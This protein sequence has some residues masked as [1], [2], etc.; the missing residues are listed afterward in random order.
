MVGKFGPIRGT[1]Q[2]MLVAPIVPSLGNWRQKNT[3]IVE[4]ARPESRLAERTSARD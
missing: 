1:S 4:I 3:T 2:M